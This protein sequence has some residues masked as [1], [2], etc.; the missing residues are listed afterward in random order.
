MALRRRALL[1][2]SWWRCWALRQR[3]RRLVAWSIAWRSVDGF[4]LISYLDDHAVLADTPDEVSVQVLQMVSDLEAC[5]FIVN[6]RATSRSRSSSRS[7]APRFGDGV[8][9]VSVKRPLLRISWGA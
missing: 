8:F 9:H 3:R 4:E 7:S 5:G 1:A 2:G 6:F